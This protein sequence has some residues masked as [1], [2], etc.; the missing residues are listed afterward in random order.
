MRTPQA[1]FELLFDKDEYTT[2]AKHKEG[3]KVYPVADFAKFDWA[4]LFCINPLHPT[5]DAKPYEDYHAPDRPRR[6]DHNV[7]KYRTFLIEMDSME[8]KAQMDYIKEIGLPYSTATYSGGKSIHF[9]ICLSTPIEDEKT[10]RKLAERLMDACGGK[11]VV[12]INC[13]NP[14]RMSR[15]P[16]ALRH[17]RDNKKQHLIHVGSRI[18]CDVLKKWIE[19]RIGPEFDA[20]QYAELTGK[21][22]IPDSDYKPTG[23]SGF[24]KN[25]LMFGD[26]T[27]IGR[28]QATFRAACDMAR[29]DIDEDDA[30]EQCISATDLEEREVVAT[31]KSAYRRVFADS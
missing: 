5:Q 21:T 15:V 1:F 17:D 20:E 26:T 18:D 25:F 12:D 4:N 19:T 28:N 30:I 8:L 14:S 31:V 7:V 11:S 6:A 10:Y 2:F 27:G 23:L 22:Y 16:D 24:T 9:L 29:N 3:T 13:K